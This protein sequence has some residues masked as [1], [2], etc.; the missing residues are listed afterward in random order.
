MVLFLCSYLL[1]QGTTLIQKGGHTFKK[2]TLTE[3]K[4]PTSG[5]ALELQGQRWWW[6]ADYRPTLTEDKRLNLPQKRGRVWGSMGVLLGSIGAVLGLLTD[7]TSR[8]AQRG[9]GPR[10]C[11]AA[12]KPGG[13]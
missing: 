12:T 7:Y 10:D 1:G 2:G 13:R 9:A 8:R 3:T 11:G 5:A 6:G 4:H